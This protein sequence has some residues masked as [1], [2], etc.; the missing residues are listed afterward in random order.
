MS[1]LAGKV[2][3]I[4]GG[5]TGI[6]LAI[7]QR[8]VAEGAHVFIFGRRRA[9]LDE[10]A[11][12][13]GRHV[14]AIQADTADLDDLDRVAAA[15]RAEKGRVDIVVS[16]AA[17]VEQQPIDT[18]TPDHFDRTFGINARGPV[19]LVQKLLPLMTGAGSIIL[20]SSAM[21]LMVHTRPH[22]LRGDQGGVAFLRPYLGRRIQGSRHPRQHVEPWRHGHTEAR[23]AGFDSGGARAA[24]EHVPEHGPDRPIVASRRGCQRG[25]LP[26]VRPKFVHDGC[27][28]DERR[29]HRAGLRLLKGMTMRLYIAG[30]TL[31]LAFANAGYGQPPS[32]PPVRSPLA[33]DANA[34]FI[35]FKVK[36]GKSAAFEKAISDVMVGVRQNEPRNVYCD[37]LHLAQDPQTYAIVERYADAGA[38]KA[39][40]DSEYIKKVG[41]VFQKD[42]LLEGPP[43]VHELV[44]IRSK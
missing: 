8:F 37:L 11:H 16:N 40:A 34:F 9:Q 43:E 29:R 25:A 38:A 18:L 28:P 7:A 3:V 33:P 36:L 32:S 15:V 12:R 41:E 6:G 39:H 44:F 42:D 35:K 5:T 17:I 24:G 20:V 26:G 14:T 21:H 22:D 1:T 19:F 13:I 10:A 31:G 23:L 27:G 30:L 2:A 4:S